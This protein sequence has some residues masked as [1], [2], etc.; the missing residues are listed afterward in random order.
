M[1]KAISLLLALLLVAALAG[2]GG[3]AAKDV[4]VAALAAELA[5]KV[6]YE[7]NEMRQLSADKLSNYVDVPDGAQAAFYMG[8][9][10]TM[11]EIIAVKCANEK[12][13]AALKT[14]METLLQ[15]QIDSV[16]PYQPESIPRLENAVLIQKGVYVA[17]CVTD[18]ADTAQKII[19][20]YLG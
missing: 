5:E 1:K 15:N 2:C 17:L 14:A 7:S 13:A 3:G 4:D 20:G 9:G 16:R 6:K 12:D 10:L 18:D 11:E 19:K 8:E